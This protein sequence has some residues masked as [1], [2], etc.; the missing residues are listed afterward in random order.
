M[1]RGL[2]WARPIEEL[3]ARA[4]GP[5]AP[6]AEL[7]ARVEEAVAPSDDAVIVYT[8][9]STALPKAV[10]HT[11]WT[12]ARHPPE[13][14][15][16]FL[17]KPEHRMFPHLP[18]FW[19]GGMAMALEVLSVGAAL[20]YSETPEL[21]DVLDTIEQLGVNRVNSWGEPLVRLR[22]GATARGIDMDAIVGLGPFRDASGE[23]I[24]Q[25]L[26]S[27]MLGMS[28]TFSV[29]SAEP[30]D[31]RLPEDKAGASGRAINGFER[32]IVDPE[33]G[34]E[35]PLGQVGELQV[36]GPALMSGF[37]K[38][39]R[40]Q[41]FTPDGFY[42]TG[43]LARLDA[44]GYLSFVAR[45]VDMIKT[46]AANVSRLEVEAALMELPEV[47]LPIVVGLPDP[48][49]GQRLVAAVVP[50]PGSAA[51]EE[52]LRAALR[53]TISSYKVPRQIVFVSHEDVPRTQTG[54]LKLSE[55]QQMVAERLGEGPGR[56]AGGDARA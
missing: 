15:K 18:A 28:E 25:P 51:S 29:H 40:S 6:D 27:N 21:S 54:K 41:V 47:E 16:L 38:V 31:A 39:P 45:R 26:Q 13:L 35:V 1:P 37:Y 20:V 34:E 23:L 55:L 22:E 10:V 46:K 7:L 17:L 36:R 24:P 44:D 43:D 2:G 11:Q 9:G 49:L 4:D 3:V 33:T 48:E 12:I 52:S 5:G 32:R 56:A 42:P 19:L 50:A 30:L 53:E 14:A 8:S